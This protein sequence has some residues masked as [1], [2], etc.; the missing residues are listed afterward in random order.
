ITVA[1]SNTSSTSLRM[2][3]VPFWSAGCPW[4]AEGEAAEGD[5]AGGA[6]GAVGWVWS[7]WAGTAT[8]TPVENRNPIRRNQ[9]VAA[10]LPCSERR[11]S[12]GPSLGA[13]LGRRVISGPGIH[14]Q[15]RQSFRRQ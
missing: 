11:P 8:L 7:G 4:L 6:A 15:R 9:K 12:L 13:S 1:C 10:R 14:S 5:A 3:K 2:T